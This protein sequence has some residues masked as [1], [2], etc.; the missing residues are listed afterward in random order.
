MVQIAYEDAQAYAKWAGKR[1][2]TEAEWEFAA[3]GGLAGKPF[4]WGD[5]FRPN[6]KWMANTHQGNF[7]NH[8]T[9]ADGYPGI[10]PVAQFPPNGYGLYDM[11]GN[12]WQWTSDWYRPDYYKQLAAGGVA[13]NPKGPD[14]VI[15]SRGADRAQEGTSRRIVSLHRSILL[16]L[17]RGHQRQ[18]RS[19]H[20]DEPSR[21]S[22]RGRCEDSRQSQVYAPK[23]G[24]R[25]LAKNISQC[26][27]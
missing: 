22:L 19:Q 2:P 11:A 6:G 17:H 8:D 23:G 4:V 18:R 3:R 27:G 20:G 12:V 5:D 26:P 14:I 13:R 25:Q 9:G 7:P 15:R 10:A 16:T 21:V 24:H 1:L